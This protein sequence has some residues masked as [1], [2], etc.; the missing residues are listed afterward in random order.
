MGPIKIQSPVKGEWSFM[1]P[2]GHHPDA[3]DFVA[4]NDKGTP[5]DW[6]KILRHLVY[7]LSVTETYAW[8]KEV[9]SPFEGVVLKVENTMP[10]RSGLNLF[11]D[12]FKGLVLAPRNGKSDIGYFLGNYVVIESPEGI[13]ALFAHL[14]QGSIVVGEG[15]NIE[16]CELLGQVGNSGNTIQPHLHF[17]LMKERDLS[18]ATPIPFVLESCQVINNG[19]W[20][21]ES[22]KLPRNYERFRV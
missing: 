10:D 21:S 12:L 5:Y 6:F 2:P 11:R 9:F 7:K 3:K 22:S 19:V 17:Q 16:G 8:E 13:L 18:Q 20:R 4:V 14:R 15:D 1:N